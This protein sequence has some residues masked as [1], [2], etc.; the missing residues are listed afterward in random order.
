MSVN[1]ENSRR[2]ATDGILG[3]WGQALE[4]KCLGGSHV[5]P[6]TPPRELTQSHQIPSTPQHRRVLT[7]QPVTPSSYIPSSS[8]IIS[9]FTVDKHH[10]LC[11]AAEIWSTQV[12]DF[13]CYAYCLKDQKIS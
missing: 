1:T 2:T 3:V 6:F 10:T 9:D 12:P 5:T 7:T 11:M 8:P 4:I 13:V